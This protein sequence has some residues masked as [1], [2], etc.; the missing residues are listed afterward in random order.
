[1]RLKTL[2][3]DADVVV[4]RDEAVKCIETKECRVIERPVTATADAEPTNRDG[5]VSRCLAIM[6]KDGNEQAGTCG[7]GHKI[8][9]AVARRKHLKRYMHFSNRQRGIIQPECNL[10]AFDVA[11]VCLGFDRHASKSLSRVTGAGM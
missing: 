2:C 4:A 5:G 11:T 9:P 3:G 8:S 6:V 1:M 7:F 10:A